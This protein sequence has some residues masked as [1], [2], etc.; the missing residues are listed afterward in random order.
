[1]DDLGRAI[2]LFCDVLGLPL[3][4]REPA[5]MVA[6]ELAIV[7]LG[8]LVLTLLCPAADGEGNLLADRTPRLSQL[9]LGVDGGDSGDAVAVLDGLLR[10][11]AEHGLATQRPA[12]GYGY[13]TPE[14]VEGAVGQRIAVVATADGP[15]DLDPSA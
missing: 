8:S 14:S 11:A 10:T 3:L 7:D 4:R 1:M 12:T 2:E 13:L 6:G 9:V 5:Q 15:A